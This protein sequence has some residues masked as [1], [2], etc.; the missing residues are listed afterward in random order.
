M[1]AFKGTPGPW[2]VGAEDADNGEIEIISE[3]RPYVCMVLPG[4][5]D[6]TTAANARLIAAAPTMHEYIA[7]RADAGDNEAKQILESI[8]AGR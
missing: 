1:S 8:N 2:S 4:E 5:I 6:D 7:K 3:A